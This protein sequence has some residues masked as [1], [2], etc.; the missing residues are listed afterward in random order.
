M[1]LKYAMADL[2]NLDI[3]ELIYVRQKLGFLGCSESEPKKHIIT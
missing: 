2:K 3:F 1:E